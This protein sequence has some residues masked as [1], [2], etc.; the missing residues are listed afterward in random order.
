MSGANNASNPNM[1]FCRGCG[2]MLHVTAVTCPNCGAPQATAHAGD[3]IPRTLGNSVSICLKKFAVF[4]GRAPRAEYWWFSL[5]MAIIGIILEGAGHAL[6]SQAILAVYGLVSLALILPSLAVT[7]RRLHDLDRSGW[8]MLLWIVPVIGWIVL[9]IWF[10]TRG[11]S[12]DNR[13]GPENGET[14]T[15]L[16]RASA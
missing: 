1:V 3:G 12:G 11:T 13:F 10:C 14:A 6:D 7:A 8:W 2:Q 16:T 15:S 5:F 4:Q 9:F